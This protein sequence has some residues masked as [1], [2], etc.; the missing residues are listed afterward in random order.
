M[1]QLSFTY[2]YRPTAGSHD[3]PDTVFHCLA[4]FFGTRKN[5][6]YLVGK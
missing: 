2:L 3:E 6:L 4:A 1:Q 5:T